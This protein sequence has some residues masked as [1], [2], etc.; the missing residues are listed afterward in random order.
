MVGTPNAL[1]FLHILQHL[2]LL[3]REGKKSNKVWEML[4]KM[5][6]SAVMISEGNE[7]GSNQF[8]S[9]SAE[10]IKKALAEINNSDEQPSSA[11]S[12]NKPQVVHP[13][14]VPPPPPP[15]FGGAPP[16]PPPPPGAPPLPSG[17]APPPPPF[18]GISTKPVEEDSQNATFK[19]SIKFVPGK[20]MKVLNWKKLPRNTV[21]NKQSVWKECVQLSEFVVVNEQQIVDLFCRAVIDS[22]GSTAEKKDTEKSKQSLVVSAQLFH[23]MLI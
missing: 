20:K 8:V 6:L 12:G 9:A 23:M 2:M 10:K 14:C 15:P 11:L 17:G 19:K 16:P 21:H 4:E 3:D 22:T 7:E 1:S 18:G 5:V 13:P